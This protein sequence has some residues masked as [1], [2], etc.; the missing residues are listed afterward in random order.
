LNLL[1]KFNQKKS[2]TMQTVWIPFSSTKNM[3]KDVRLSLPPLPAG[4]IYMYRENHRI[5]RTSKDPE[6]YHDWLTV[7]KAN[8]ESYRPDISPMSYIMYA[9]TGYNF[10][11]SAGV[12]VVTIFPDDNQE[13]STRK[14]VPYRD[15]FA[16]YSMHRHTAIRFVTTCYPACPVLIDLCCEQVPEELG[17][18][19]WYFRFTIADW[20]Y[21]YYIYDRKLTQTVLTALMKIRSHKD[22]FLH[23]SGWEYLDH[24]LHLGCVDD[25]MVNTCDPGAN[26]MWAVFCQKWTKDDTHTYIC[27]FDDCEGNDVKVEYTR[28]SNLQIHRRGLTT[29]YDR[30]MWSAILK[31]IEMKSAMK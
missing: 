25:T 7:E 12:S 20:G 28:G 21:T 9:L 14:E 15:Q 13:E 11:P 19:E 23:I 2:V 5:F 18:I 10:A 30:T 16:N 3:I 26:L 27:R 31:H 8:P 17:Q 22:Q 6:K 1:D 4:V 29:D 24:C